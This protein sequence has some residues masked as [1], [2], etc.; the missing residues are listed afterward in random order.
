MKRNE[1]RIDF[2]AV[3]P[4][5][6]TSDI[7]ILLSEVDKSTCFNV[8]AIWR[9]RM[10]E[11]GSTVWNSI[12]NSYTNGLQTLPIAV[13]IAN[14]LPYI[15]QYVQSLTINA[16]QKVILERY[17]EYFENGKFKKIKSLHLGNK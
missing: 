4:L 12:L 5:E 7:L 17:M 3:L 6:L 8:S 15:A 10:I 11:G 13:R 2:I 9:K 1:T 14:T 16:K